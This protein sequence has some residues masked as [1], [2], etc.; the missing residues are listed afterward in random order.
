M[1]MTLDITVKSLNRRRQRNSTVDNKIIVT[2]SYYHLFL[3]VT[4]QT[5]IIYRNIDVEI[6]LFVEFD[7][8]LS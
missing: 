8:L 7:V 1:G 4:K 6:K 5:Y 3:Q 2:K